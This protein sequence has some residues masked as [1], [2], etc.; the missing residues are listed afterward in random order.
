VSKHDASAKE[1]PSLKSYSEEEIDAFL[2]GDRRVID[3]LLLHGLNNLAVVLIAH[4][5][6]EEEIFAGM[7]SAETIK[8]RSDWIDSQIE[9]NRVRGDMMQKVA[10]STT[11]WAV[12]AF[13][14]YLIHAAWEYT[15]HLIK[16]KTGV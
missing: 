8:K 2:D 11:A 9:S 14:G 12:I 6:R 16:T 1:L 3:R 4:A 10:V 7:G 15:T 13:I 5:E